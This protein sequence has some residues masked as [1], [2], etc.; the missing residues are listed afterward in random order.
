[1]VVWQDGGMVGWWYGKILGGR[2]GERVLNV[3]GWP[4]GSGGC[5][6]R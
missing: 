5:T 2:R 1:M 4:V 3:P 6:D